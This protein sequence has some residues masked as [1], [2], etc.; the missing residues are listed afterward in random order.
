[1]LELIE[2]E[3]YSIFIAD[4]LRKVKILRKNRCSYRVKLNYSDD[5]FSWCG[6]EATMKWNE[7]E[8][9][10][11]ILDKKITIPTVN[12]LKIYN[13]NKIKEELE[14]KIKLAEDTI[15][16]KEQRIDELLQDVKELKL[17]IKNLTQEVKVI[18]K[19]LDSL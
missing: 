15:E 10:F 14:S 12:Q 1:M 8:E 19:E 17:K 13:K 16:Y 6:H 11:Y 4:E 18:E 5:Y 2:K 3:V 7:K 9:S